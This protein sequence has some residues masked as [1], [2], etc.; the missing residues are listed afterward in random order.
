MRLSR[1]LAVCLA[2][3]VPLLFPSVGKAQSG[4]TVRGTVTLDNNGSPLHNVTVQIVQLHRSTE[5]NQSGEYS[6]ENVPPGR[7]TIL[8]HLDRFPDFVETITVA[9]GAVN[10][11]D[12]ELSLTSIE[13]EVTVTATGHEESTLDT[14]QTVT[15]LNSIELT[16]KANTS[17]GEVLEDEPGVAKKSFGPGGARPV[18][19]GFD[20][21][22]VLI[23]QDGVTSGTLS[24][25]SADHGES[26]NVLTLDKV[27]VVKGPATLLYGSNAIGGVVNT[28]SGH[29]QIHDHA[30]EGVRGYVN[31]AGGS[32]NALAGVGA[33]VEFGTDE[34]MFWANGGGI[35]TGDYDTPIGEIPNSRSR[36]G[37]VSGGGGYFGERGFFSANYSYENSRYGIPFAAKFHGHHEEEEGEGGHKGEEE[38][39]SVALKR[40]NVRLIG[41]FRDLDSPIVNGRFQFNATNYNHV[42]LE[43]EAIG[44]T[45]DNDVFSYRGDLDHKQAGRFSGSLGFSGLHR[46]YVTVGEE[47]LAPPVVQNGFAVFALEH[48]DFEHARFQFGARVE[49]TAYDVATVELPDRSFTGLSGA[50]GINVPLWEGGSFVANYTHSR[51]APSL[52]ELYN[53]GPHL[54][55]LTF[56]VGNPYLEDERS[57]GAELSFRHSRD[58]VRAQANFYYFRLSDFVFLAPTG[59][60]EDG[61][62]VA[63]YLQGDSRFVG[64]ELG[65]DVDVHRN[66]TLSFMLDAVDAELTDT[67]TPLPRIPPLRGGVGV[68]VT[69]KG[70]RVHPEV[71]LVSDQDQF[72]ANETRTAGYARFDVDASYTWGYQHFAHVISVSA[73]NLG[74]RLYRNHLSLIKELAPEIGRGVRVSYTMRFF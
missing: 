73:F 61:F 72:F 1:T 45:F 70:F 22:R 28:I 48:V 20:G 30:Y 17:I 6:I 31:A 18:I 67:G 16:Q 36:T 71:T 58:R 57:N 2:L 35:R 60:E 32:T 29:G 56:E 47:A 27:E 52:E 8:A 54:A 39:V 37:N 74:D 65:L 51:R 3:V 63:N 12:F 38:L 9:A 15:T 46:D 5:T 59:E 62:P 26:F 50:A 68:D 40:H 11:V 19:R 41:G 13:E 64:G 24:S 69:Y 55:N 34:F 25:Q 49:H 10:E 4:G 21:D 66:V 7:Y 42:E 23:L 14:F 33:G 43:G 53:F 44:T